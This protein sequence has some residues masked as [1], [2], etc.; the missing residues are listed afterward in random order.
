MRPTAGLRNEWPFM[1]RDAELS[2]LRS[3]VDEA[4]DD[5]VSG[6]VLAGASGVGKT[7][8][9]AELLRIASAEGRTTLRAIATHSAAETPFAAL[10]HL[11]STSSLHQHQDLASWFREF[12]E[13]LRGDS[14]VRPLL[15]VDD[16]HLL[17]A[18]S[19]ALVLHLAMT[20]AAS[21][22]VA[23]RRGESVPDPI[24]AL[25][26]DELVARIDLQPLSRL[27]TGRMI[28]TALGGRV[29]LHTRHRL[30]EVADGNALYV[31]E[32]V[33]GALEADAL[34]RGHDGVWRWDG[35]LVLAPRLV[36]AVSQR[37]A[38]LDRNEQHALALV[39]AAEPLALDHLEQLTDPSSVVRLERLGLVQI[40]EGLHVPECRV[41]HPLHGEVVLEQL[42][43]VGRRHLYRQLADDF[44]AR[45]S[46][47]DLDLLRVATWRLE[48]GGQLDG[49]RL[50]A[51]AVLANQAF[52][53]PLAERLARAARERGSHG[54]ADVALAEALSNQNRHAD[55]EAVLAQSEAKVLAFPDVGLHQR[56]LHVRHVALY[57]GLGRPEEHLAMLARFDAA[58]E[59]V[60]NEDR[61]RRAR[62][63]ASGYRTSVLLD[64][65]RLSDVL[66]TTERLLTD[67][68][69]VGPLP[70]LLALETRAEALGYLGRVS[71]ARAIH[72]ELLELAAS[73]D[74]LV[75]R[76]ETSALMQGALCLTLEGEVGQ[77]METVSAVRERVL[78]D[79][80]PFVHSLVSMVLG[81]TQLL[82]GRPA[83]ARRT[84]HDALTGFSRADLG[85]S[86]AWIWAMIAQCEA[87][88]GD[89][90]AARRGLVESDRLRPRHVVAR[91]VMDTV[92]AEAA[93]VAAE[94][95]LSRAARVC[96]DGVDQLGELHMYRARLL[97]RSG[98]LAPPTRATLSALETIAESVECAMP[99]M[100]VAHLRAL[101]D[102]DAAGLERLSERFEGLGVG[103]EAAEAAAQSSRA[104]ARAGDA[105]GARRLAGR[106]RRLVERGEGVRTPTLTLAATAPQLS[107]REAQ[108]AHLA[109][110]G[111]SNAQIADRL[112]LS[113][114]TVESHLYQVFAKLGVERRDQLVDQL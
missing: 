102:H 113:V 109:A 19:A 98:M 70:T 5:R 82:S 25:W 60:T 85:G 10:A 52:D 95:D 34:Q 104:H 33:L 50:A 55:A 57:L 77:A 28:E 107:R 16:A 81:A 45:E 17:D 68:T 91:N 20:R 66:E 75:R 61:A 69:A 93:V 64:A 18:G 29:S 30:V 37:L 43:A 22:V 94:G 112:V 78:D 87:L 73:G 92:L 49:E 31:R 99:A 86:L 63:A 6:A 7:A 101:L 36:D 100:F 32:L 83:T 96:I 72:A 40:A 88:T 67:R 35:P 4:K 106:T 41:G 80:D 103:L 42:G 54:L 8:L 26:R 21:V 84:L 12:G 71:C 110:Q 53:R 51:A 24:T 38:G 14:E 47:G 39:A 114:R 89:P 48:G 23:I 62:Q 58:H 1:A 108:V 15:V 105:G 111:L 3:L 27:E 74:P 65:G 59:G 97:H 9:L 11:A 79:P 90:G 2:L 13:A 46:G 44:E 56:Y 76:A